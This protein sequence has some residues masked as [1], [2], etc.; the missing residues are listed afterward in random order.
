MPCSFNTPCQHTPILNLC[1]LIFGL[2]PYGWLHS[3]MLTTTYFIIYY[4]KII[5]DLH[6]LDSSPLF[7]E[8]KQGEKTRMWCNKALFIRGETTSRLLTWLWIRLWRRK[9][10]IWDIISHS[11]IDMLA[12]VFLSL[13]LRCSVPWLSLCFWIWTNNTGDWGVRLFPTSFFFPPVLAHLS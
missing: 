12:A 3:I 8:H 5:F 2:T 13:F 4:A 6:L 7:Q 11:T 1:P 10:V 9:G